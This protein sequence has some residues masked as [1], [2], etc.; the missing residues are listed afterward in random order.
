MRGW[1]CGTLSVWFPS[2]LRTKL[3]IQLMS[4]FISPLGRTYRGQLLGYKFVPYYLLEGWTWANVLTAPS[5]SFFI[6]RCHLWQWY[7]MGLSWGQ[8]RQSMW[9][10]WRWVCSMLVIITWGCRH[11]HRSLRP[12][13]RWGFL[14]SS[15]TVQRLGPQQRPGE[16][17]ICWWQGHKIGRI[18]GK[19][20]AQT[21]FH[22]LW[23]TYL[24]QSYYYPSLVV[25]SAV[26][27]NNP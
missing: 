18:L 20:K 7:L 26:I 8:R 15:P 23:S 2:T 14:T 10:P 9:C 16:L 17:S 3:C 22:H 6:G 13:S 4:F 21:I 19:E 11:P 27:T 1:G 12:Y 5:L 25:S 24:L